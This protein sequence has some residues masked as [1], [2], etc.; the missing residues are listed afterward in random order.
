MI[1]DLPDSSFEHTIQFEITEPLSTDVKQ[2]LINCARY[3]Y[4][5][6]INIIPDY[7]YDKL[8]SS[9]CN[10]GACMSPIYENDTIPYDSFKRLFG[11]E[12]SDIII[13]ILEGEHPSADTNP[14]DVVQ[15]ISNNRSSIVKQTNKFS[16]DESTVSAPPDIKNHNVQTAPAQCVPPCSYTEN[17]MDILNESASLSIHATWEYEEAYNWFRNLRGVPVVISPKIDGINTRSG[18]RIISQG[19]LEH[20]ISATRG[21][22]CDPL[23]ITHNMRNILPQQ[24]SMNNT[25]SL[26]I[27]SETIADINGLELI[28]KNQGPTV[29]KVPR[30]LALS[31]MRTTNYTEDMYSHLHSLV[32]KVS[33]GKTLIEG[34]ELAEQWGFET[35]PYVVYTCN[36]TSLDKFVAELRPMLLKMKTDMADKGIVTDGVVAEVND[37]N[38]FNNSDITN[39]YSAA[40]IALKM[41][42]WEAGE[43]K[44]IVESFDI[45]SNGEQ[46]C[47][48]AIVK[49]VISSNGKKLSRVNCFNLATIIS[50]DI[51][52]GSEIAFKYKND[53]TI[54][55]I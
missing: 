6:G 39:C 24:I 7:K 52:V 27:Y 21:R 22:T 35:V 41:E 40:N 49:P 31:M 48:V 44:S 43:Y 42:F 34:L 33:S 16:I 18:Y 47:C 20:K 2:D 23:N 55:L 12:K 4:A 54:E 19:I 50:K 32:F 13:Q 10:E 9:M 30:G 3:M 46:Y 53:T 14:I 37:R 15:S 29:Y 45:S 5:K 17:N 38:M 26:V 51:Q 8:V 28:N 1:V 25:E 11:W 36:S